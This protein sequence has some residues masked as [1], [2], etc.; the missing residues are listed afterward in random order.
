[1]NLEAD[2]KKRGLK[3]FRLRDSLAKKGITF[4]AQAPS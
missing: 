1:M 2:L 3:I 4:M